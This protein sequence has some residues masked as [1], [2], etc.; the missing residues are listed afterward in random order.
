MCCNRKF[1]CFHW[2]LWGGERIKSETCIL[3]LINSLCGIGLAVKSTLR[4]KQQPLKERKGSLVRSR[5][6]DVV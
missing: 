4:R 6:S 5:D 3:Y 1:L 2:S